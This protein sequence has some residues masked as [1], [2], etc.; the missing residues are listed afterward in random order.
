M[1]LQMESKSDDELHVLFGCTN[2]SKNSTL[3]AYFQHIHQEIQKIIPNYVSKNKKAYFIYKLPTGASKTLLEDKYGYELLSTKNYTSNQTEDMS[4][5]EFIR[6]HPH[7]RFDVIVLAQCSNLID[8]I[9]YD[10]YDFMDKENIFE[11]VKTFYHSSAPSGLVFN[12]YYYIPRDPNKLNLQERN[13]D[14][15]RKLN[16]NFPFLNDFMTF[17]SS[18]VFEHIDLY[19]FLVKVMNRLYYRISTGVY[20][21]IPLSDKQIDN[22]LKEEYNKTIQEISEMMKLE[23]NEFMESFDKNYL[24]SYHP[25]FT[26]DDLEHL[27]KYKLK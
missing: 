27:Y 2:L 21:K 16:P 9:T 26:F 17:Y 11:N 15:I 8:T 7:L 1:I 12:F 14:K 4:I 13:K 18:S 5:L 19:I 10:R 6:E 24:D 20:Q 22:L 3:V 23:S 25:T